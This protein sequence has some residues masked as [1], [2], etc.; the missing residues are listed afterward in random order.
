M[1]TVF[2]FGLIAVVV[3]ALVLVHVVRMG[4]RFFRGDEEMVSG[5]S[6]GI[7]LFG[8]RKDRH[9]PSTRGGHH[10]SRLDP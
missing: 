5:G 1:D 4:W 6:W 8:R 2:F 3:M 7:Q 10:R 9:D